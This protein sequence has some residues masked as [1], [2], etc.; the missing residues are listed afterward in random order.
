[1]GEVNQ[2]HLVPICSAVIPTNPLEL[3][4]LPESFFALGK[5]SFRIP[6]DSTDLPPAESNI[7]ARNSNHR[8]TSIAITQSFHFLPPNFVLACI[9]VFPSATCLNGKDSISQEKSE[10]STSRFLKLLLFAIPRD[11]HKKMHCIPIENPTEPI[12]LLYLRIP[13][14]KILDCI[15]LPKPANRFE[16]CA[17][18]AVIVILSSE[19]SILLG[20]LKES[21]TKLEKL[22][23]TY[24]QGIETPMN[25]EEIVRC[26][27]AIFSLEKIQTVILLPTQSETNYLLTITEAL[28]NA[29]SS[30]SNL[31]LYW[32]PE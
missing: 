2:I 20:S 24:H 6:L 19:H 31:N 27:K 15:L 22:M 26:K 12:P 17:V 18:S 7:S 14:V 1:L 10:R 21:L 9:N 4:S 29:H 32:F 11:L 23:K 3:C 5:F 8:Q 30:T 25:S 13:S 16:D 28:G